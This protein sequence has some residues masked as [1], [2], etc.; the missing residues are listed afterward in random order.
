MDPSV[1]SDINILNIPSYINTS[2]GHDYLESSVNINKY[3]NNVAAKYNALYNIQ[4]N[5]R[6]WDENM[7]LFKLNRLMIILEKKMYCS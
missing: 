4:K 5:D 6:T 7:Q 2:N 3:Y 1:R